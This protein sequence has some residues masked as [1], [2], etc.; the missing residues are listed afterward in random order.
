MNSGKLDSELDQYDLLGS[1]E[2][3][4][5]S[6]LPETNLSA[7]TQAFNTKIQRRKREQE[8][9]LGEADR[10]AK[11]RQI[12]MI[13]TLTS[14]RRS[15]RDVTRID[16]GDRFHFSLQAD[17]W[18]GW[19][20]LIIRL[21]DGLLPQ[22]S[23]PF[24]R[25]TGHDRQARGAIE[26]EYDPNSPTESISL[27]VESELKRLPNLLKKCVRSFLDLTGDIVLEAER[28]TDEVRA[29][30]PIV[31]RTLDHF[32]ESKR[33]DNQPMLSGDVFQDEVPEQDFLETLPSL[34][35]VQSLPDAD[36]SILSVKGKSPKAI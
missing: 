5:Q 24:L 36:M 20:R 22:A 7:T 30:A 34:D 21:V 12:L 16:L 14:I 31:N 15:L 11:Q 13:Q 25:V 17:D 1:S 10:L 29:E 4:P 32:E 2:E 33:S 28:N 26:I 27:A 6:S 35:E 3:A 23:Y 18:Q 9:I 8:K 19:P